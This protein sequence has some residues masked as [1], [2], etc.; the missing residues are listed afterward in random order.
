MSQLAEHAWNLSKADADP[1]YADIP[2]NGFKENLDFRAEKVK[3]TGIAITPF[4]IM[5]EG[6][7]ASDDKV[8]EAA[9]AVAEV[10]VEEVVPQVV[11]V[12]KKA[13]AKK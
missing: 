3:E 7:L 8:E 9:E 1:S 11:K 6:L 2:D 4:E 5:V 10:V 12:P 13:K